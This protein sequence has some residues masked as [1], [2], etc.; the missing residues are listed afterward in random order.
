M[1]DQDPTTTPSPAPGSDAPAVASFSLRRAAEVAG[2]SVSTL[3]RHRDALVAAG[4]TVSPSGWNVPV[5]ALEAVG[6][7]GPQ[8]ATS[9]PRTAS[10]APKAP[11]GDQA[12]AEAVQRA[13]DAEARV[14]ELEAQL[15]DARHRATLAEAIAHERLEALNAERMALR[16]LTTLTSTPAPST[17]AEEP[18]G[19][20]S[21]AGQ[22][23]QER[24]TTGPSSTAQHASPR[25]GR[26]RRLFG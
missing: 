8:A 22:P 5:T 12:L 23:A 24:D 26:W 21:H 17:P 3:R 18:P 19:P 25:S 16:M 6:L 10:Q 4:A 14:T 20:V 1:S 9:A 11:E 2:V 13:Q 7:I 15:L